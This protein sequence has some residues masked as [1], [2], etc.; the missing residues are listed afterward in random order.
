MNEYQLIEFTA[1][2]KITTIHSLE[3]NLYNVLA[4]FYK[5]NINAL[6]DDNTSQAKGFISIFLNS[7]QLGSIEGVSL[8]HRDEIQIVT[9]IAGG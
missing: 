8:N 1:Q 9:S 4:D 3:T 5:D 7:R 6:F 2:K